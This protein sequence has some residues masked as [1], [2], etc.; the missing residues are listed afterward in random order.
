MICQTSNEPDVAGG[1][2]GVDVEDGGELG[3]EGYEGSGGGLE[4]RGVAGRGES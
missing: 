4:T 1:L 3:D 2:D